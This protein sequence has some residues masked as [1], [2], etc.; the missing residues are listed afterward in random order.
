MILL[1]CVWNL[2]A[3]LTHPVQYSHRAFPLGPQRD[4]FLAWS[5]LSKVEQER[6]QDG[7]VFVPEDSRRMSIWFDYWPSVAWT[8]AVCAVDNPGFLL[9]SD[10]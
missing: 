1:C 5:L 10:L 9:Y 6:Q 8:W 3:T 4:H 2:D 7:S